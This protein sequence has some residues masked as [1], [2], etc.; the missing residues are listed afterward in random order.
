MRD[1][2]DRDAAI[3]RRAYVL[4]DALGLPHAQGRGGLV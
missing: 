1:E 4:Q 3:G 2:H